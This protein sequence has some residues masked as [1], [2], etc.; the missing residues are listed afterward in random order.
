MPGGDEQPLL[1]AP[2][3]RTSCCRPPLSSQVPPHRRTST[4]SPCVQWLNR[5]SHASRRSGRHPSRRAAP[6]QPPSKRASGC[7]ARAGRPSGQPLRPG[8]LPGCWRRPRSCAAAA[9]PQR[10]CAGCSKL[11]GWNA[12]TRERS[13]AGS[14]GGSRRHSTAGAPAACQQRR[15]APGDSSSGPQLLSDTEC[16]Q[17]GS[18][19]GRQRSSP[20]AGVPRLLQLLRDSSSDRIY[21]SAAFVLLRI[22][23]SVTAGREKSLRAAGLHPWCCDWAAAA[24]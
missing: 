10:T 18:R 11:G 3:L 21:Q 22:A 8:R 17:C 19:A 13:R 12:G 6:E 2:L 4:D 20:A 23:S 1:M 14:A 16:R 7:S 9:Q 5:P 24:L 15:W